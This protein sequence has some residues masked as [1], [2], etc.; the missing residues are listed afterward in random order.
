VLVIEVGDT[1]EEDIPWG[2]GLCSIPVLLVTPAEGSCSSETVEVVDRH[3]LSK[4]GELVLAT[5]WAM[6][7]EVVNA[8]LNLRCSC[9]HQ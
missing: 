5:R 1:G 3:L 6:L 9:N 8:D 4:V 7:P 2:V